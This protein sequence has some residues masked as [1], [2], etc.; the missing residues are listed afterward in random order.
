VG[1]S[2]GG[3][4]SAQGIERVRLGGRTLATALGPVDLHDALAGAQQ[5]AA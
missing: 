4:G 2:Q 1:A 3:A 5:M